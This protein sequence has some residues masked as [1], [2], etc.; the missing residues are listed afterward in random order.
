MDACIGENFGAENLA[1][2]SQQRSLL[3]I[4]LASHLWHQKSYD[5]LVPSQDPSTLVKLLP[6]NSPLRRTALFTC[7]RVTALSKYV[8]IEMPWEDRFRYFQQPT[9]IPPHSLLLGYFRGLKLPF[10]KLGQKLDELPIKFGEMLDEQG[11]RG[12][13][14]LDHIVRAVEQA[15]QLSGISKDVAHIK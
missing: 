3:R 12:G 7:S 9:G 11:T 1:S 15:L 8:L 10:G 5:K 13:L 6:N 2:S 4:G 14:T